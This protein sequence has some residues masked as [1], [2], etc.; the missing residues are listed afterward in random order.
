M[1][2]IWDDFAEKSFDPITGYDFEG[3]RIY[4]ST[5]PGFSDMKPITDA[6]GSIAY[7]EPLAQFDLDNNI[8]GLA[9]TPVNGV[10]FYLG[11][12][13]GLVHSFEDTTVTNGQ[14]YY[15]AITSY[16]S[17]GDIR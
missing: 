8:E 3:Y 4:R 17:G 16:D 9:P 7:R 13:T 12:N 10:H 11:K 2:L 5:D 1:T 6:Y 14:L 15:Y